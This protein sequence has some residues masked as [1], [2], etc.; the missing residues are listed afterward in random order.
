MITGGWPASFTPG[1]DAGDPI[2]EQIE[3]NRAQATSVFPVLEDIAI[4]QVATD[5]L[6]SCTIDHIP[7][8]DKLEN[9]DNL[10]VGTGWTGHGFAISPV[11][12]EL[13]AEWAYTDERP[14]L[15]APFSY[16]RFL[17]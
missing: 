14:E 3:Q 13:L 17:I 12:S 15:L 9:V 2:P 7:I 11:V 4:E 10:L 5:H 8:I 16:D 1:D 6:E